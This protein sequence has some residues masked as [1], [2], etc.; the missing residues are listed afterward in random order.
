MKIRLSWIAV[1]VLLGAC[2]NFQPTSVVENQPI[3]IPPSPQIQN[4]ALES[5]STPF[6]V[7]ATL[8]CTNSLRFIADQTI[9]DGSKVKPG[10]TLEKVWE[11]ENDGTCNWDERYRLKWIGGS[12]IGLAAEQA[13]FP[14][15][16]GTQALIRIIL[17]TP[18][19]P[20]TYHSA[21]QAY[22]PQGQPFG[23]PIYIEFEVVAQ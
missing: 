16:S 13:L 6:P 20:A 11:V 1:L 22:D 17:V 8:V 21:W 2:N 14:A 3:Y 18:N 4:T 23:D 7:T 5:Q 19:E 9:P 10:E 15:R 12:E